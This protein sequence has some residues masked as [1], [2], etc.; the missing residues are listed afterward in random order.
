MA[1]DIDFLIIGGGAAGIGAARR[2]AALGASPLD[3]E[4]LDRIGGRAHTIE[5]RGQRLDLGCEWLHSGDRNVWTGIAEDLGF[6]VDRRDPVWGEQFRDLGFPAADQAA[7][8]RAFDAWAERLIRSPPAS[9]RSSDALEP[10]GEWN[11]F[12]AAMTG[13]ISGAAPERLSAE[14]YVAYERAATEANWRLPAGYGTLVAASL[15]A[16]V[17]VRTDTRVE[18]IDLA[19]RGVVVVTSRGTLRARAVI[20][21]VPTSVL[22]DGAIRLPPEVD[23]WRVAAAALPLGRD[24][25]VFLEI[26]GDAPFEDETYVLGNPR[27]ARTGGHYIR[28][29]GAPVIECFLGGGA[30]DVLDDGPDAGF[31]FAVDEIV[32]LFGSDARRSLRPL[33]VSNW[34]QIAT[35]GGAYSYALPGHA[36]ARALL[37]KPFDD[38]LFF[39]GEAT[40]PFD[41]T[42]AHGAHDS[43]VRAADE[44]FASASR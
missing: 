27:T 41:F 11:G 35:I 38:C 36:G 23:P 16:S 37:A 13:F 42:T 20:V 40:H 8:G 25:K 44:A 2:L 6:R 39:A 32:A 18:A 1:D 5:A 9:D 21:A 12:I 22:A 34:S 26:I 24:E 30:A 4:A 15:P 19:A 3:V 28:P 31:A 14:D 7:A 33:A 29:L 10:N 17:A 43:G